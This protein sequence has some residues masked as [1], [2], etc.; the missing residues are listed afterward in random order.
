MIK[1][2]LQQNKQTTKSGVK[3]CGHLG[4]NLG[5]SR[6]GNDFSI[7]RGLIKYKWDLLWH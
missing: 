6:E 2:L 3:T 4:H 5:H 1:K 7:Q